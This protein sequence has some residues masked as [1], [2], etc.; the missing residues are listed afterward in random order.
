MARMFLCDRCGK[1]LH[2]DR[3]KLHPYHIVENR[4]K[5]YEEIDLCEE[6]CYFVLDAI[7]EF[8]GGAD[9]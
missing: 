5:K 8:N 2:E 4:V 9:E 1:Q 6:C 7:Y 3:F